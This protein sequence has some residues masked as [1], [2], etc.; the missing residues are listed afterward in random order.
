MPRTSPFFFILPLL[1]FGWGARGRLRAQ[2]IQETQSVIAV[3]V[4]VQVLKGGKPLRGLS[5]ANF[6]VFDRDSRQKIT[7]FEVVD[8]EDLRAYDDL[9]TINPKRQRRF[10]FFFDLYFSSPP[11]LKNAKKAIQ[12]MIYDGMGLDDKIAVAVYAPEEGTILLT[13]FTSDEVLIE[14]ALDAVDWFMDPRSYRQLTRDTNRESDAAARKDSYWWEDRFYVEG[15][16]KTGLKLESRL[17]LAR[18]KMVFRGEGDQAF[19]D[20]KRHLDQLAHMKRIGSPRAQS[21]AVFSMLADLALLAHAIK[22]EEGGRYLVFLSEGF[23]NNLALAGGGGD[24]IQSHFEH[25]L[26]VFRQTGWALHAIDVRGLRNQGSSATHDSLY[27]LAQDTGG[28]FYRNY[29]DL[30]KAFRTLEQNTSLTYVL[31]FQP[32]DIEQDGSFHDIRV[33]LKKVPGR[34]RIQYARPGYFAPY[35]ASR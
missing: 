21:K 10:L 5:A 13:G 25:M 33:K 20:L 29:N 16:N 34:A 9:E 17:K 31:S 6:E 1:V 15:R 28:S 19:I 11:H 12:D 7:A 2:D 14:T 3:K 8:L 22:V 32:A 35:T 27:R 30:N 26:A 18:E 4:P 24:M 23:P